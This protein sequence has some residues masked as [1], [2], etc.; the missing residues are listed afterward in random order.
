MPP[1]VAS[2]LPVKQ[3]SVLNLSTENSPEDLALTTDFFFLVP[4]V[5]LEP[6]GKM[7]L[8]LAADPEG[9]QKGLKVNDISPAGKAGQAGVQKGD[10]LL[11][12]NDTAVN[13]MEDVQLILMNFQAGDQVKLRL[14]RQNKKQQPEEKELELELSNLEKHKMVP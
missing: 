12:I 8:V 11:A 14:R 7:G 1:R 4:P 6:I 13:S 10:I 9:K 3:A 5:T 2:R